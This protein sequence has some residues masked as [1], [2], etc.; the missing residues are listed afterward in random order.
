MIQGGGW[1]ARVHESKAEQ[2]EIWTAVSAGFSSPESVDYL[3]QSVP[4]VAIALA[5]RQAQQVPNAGLAVSQGFYR[6]LLRPKICSELISSFI[7]LLFAQSRQRV[8]TLG[9]FWDFVET[10]DILLFLLW[11]YVN[12]SLLAVNV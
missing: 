7:L 9:V 2:N 8:E 1:T 6:T 4:T 11:L 12:V 10:H 5:R 3:F